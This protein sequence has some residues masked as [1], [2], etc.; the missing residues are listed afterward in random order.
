MIH[1][2]ACTRHH[3]YAFT[4]KSVNQGNDSFNYVPVNSLMNLVV[5]KHKTYELLVNLH[6]MMPSSNMLMVVVKWIM[7]CLIIHPKPISV[8]SCMTVQA[9]MCPCVHTLVLKLIVFAAFF[10]VVLITVCLKEIFTICLVSQCWHDT[11][12]GLWMYTLL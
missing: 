2:S 7:S 6:V 8:H 11:S 4:Q 10:L 1:T 9:N 5:Q 12:V 3:Y